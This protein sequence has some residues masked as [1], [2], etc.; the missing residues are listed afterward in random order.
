MGPDSDGT[1]RPA[2]MV[3][4]TAASSDPRGSADARSDAR[5]AADL[6]DQAAGRDE[7][8]R[9]WQPLVPVL[10][11]QFRHHNRLFWR[12]PLMATATLALP[13]GLL[14]LLRVIYEDDLLL[15]LGDIV[16][17]FAAFYAPAMAAFVGAQATYGAL[18]V[19]LAQQRD[20]GVLKRIRATPV[21]VPVYLGGALLSSLWIALLGSVLMM[22]AGVLAFQL[23]IDWA[24]MP[25]FGINYIIGVTCFAA[26]GLALAA[27]SP[28]GNAAPAIAN[29]TMLPVA[30]I[31]NVFIPLVDPPDWLD[32]LGDMLPLKPFAESL[33]ASFDPRP[34]IALLS[35]SRIGVLVVWTIIGLVVARLFFRWERR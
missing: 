4:D 35:P 26:L 27:L 18:G 10:M 19:N 14:A 33:Q 28:G 23:D 13:L 29:A 25:A 15:W 16:T 6:G 7:T 5:G 8:L 22:V 32:R 30:F 11:A 3:N 24:R 1:S 21:P 2:A 20:Q 31:S 9:G 17:T 34:N 12:S